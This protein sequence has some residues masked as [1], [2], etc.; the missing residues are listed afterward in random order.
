MYDGM[1]SEL[2]L[3]H[4]HIGQLY[5]IVGDHSQ[6]VAYFKS[7]LGMARKTDNPCDAGEAFGLLAMAYG[8]SGKLSAFLY[9]STLSR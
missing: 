9:L 6:A 3:L 5:D 7:H 8:K 2:S 4:K 1:I